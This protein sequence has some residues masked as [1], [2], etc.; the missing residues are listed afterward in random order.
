[1]NER[2]GIIMMTMLMLMVSGCK[3]FESVVETGLHVER[4][5]E[6]L[7]PLPAVPDL[8]LIHI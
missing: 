4:Y 7:E 3:R 2:T 5:A 1:M 8:S 6:S